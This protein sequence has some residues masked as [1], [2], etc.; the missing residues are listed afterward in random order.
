MSIFTHLKIVD[1]SKNARNEVI[2]INENK[3][4]VSNVQTLITRIKIRFSLN[5]KNFF[6]ITR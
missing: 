5:L 3:N 4:I 2:N 6:S 1:N